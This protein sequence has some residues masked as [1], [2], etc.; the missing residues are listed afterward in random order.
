M[1]PGFLPFVL[2]AIPHPDPVSSRFQLAMVTIG[3]LVAAVVFFG[4]KLIARRGDCSDRVSAVFGYAGSVLTLLV[5]F[6]Q[7]IELGLGVLAVLAFG[8]G[9]A[10][11][12]GLLFA[13]RRLPWN[14]KKSWSGLLSFV[15]GATFM[16]SLVYWGETNFNPWA[17]P[18]IV[19]FHSALAV[20]GTAS[21][22][23]AVVE[24]LPLR[25]NDNVSVGITA[26][27]AMIAAHAAFVGW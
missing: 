1:A 11:A 8:D 26:S 4:F 15:A 22:A 19:P 7:H 3:A 6:P 18:P 17:S 27:L 20:G 2:W 12:G 14:S 24:S 21:L 16:A 13:G 23:G 10:T 9:S 5:L 25:L